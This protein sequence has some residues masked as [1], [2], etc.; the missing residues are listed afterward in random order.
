MPIAL[1][2]EMCLEKWGLKL[3]YFSSQAGG[4]LN[5]T[6]SKYYLIILSA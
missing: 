5:T 1:I 4:G 6:G 3:Y 2:V